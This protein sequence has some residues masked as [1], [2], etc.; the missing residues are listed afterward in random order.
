LARSLEIVEAPTGRD[1]AATVL[2]HTATTA[3]ADLIHRN[4]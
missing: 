1:K 4:R 2:E 3:K